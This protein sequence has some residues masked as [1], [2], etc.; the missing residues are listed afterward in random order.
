M[1]S[2]PS[3]RKRKGNIAPQIET[4]F[5]GLQTARI[6]AGSS[7]S[8]PRPQKSLGH[9]RCLLWSTTEG[10]DYHVELDE[11]FYSVSYCHAREQVDVRYTKTT[12]EIFLRGQ[13]IA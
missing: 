1:R 2:P 5:C 6:S 13:R 7:S 9:T 11:H 8:V 3:A 4:C 12:V 10:I